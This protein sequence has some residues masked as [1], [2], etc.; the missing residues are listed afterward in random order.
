VLV[1][2]NEDKVPAKMR[3]LREYNGDKLIVTYDPEGDT[4]IGLEVAYSLARA[5]VLMSRSESGGVDSAAVR[6]TVERALTAT[7]DV[8][9]IKSQLSGAE[10]S[11][12]NARELLDEMAERVREHLRQIDGLVLSA[13]EPD[14]A[15]AGETQ[16]RLL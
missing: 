11:I 7:E 15:S 4:G 9:R 14:E 13:E 6:D 3:P 1:V 8:R 12:G 2:P 10:T 5:R 16:E